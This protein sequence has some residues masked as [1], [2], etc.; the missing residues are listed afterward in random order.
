MYK[1][2]PAFKAPDDRNAKIWHYMDI[3]KFLSLIM[4]RKLFFGRLDRTSDPLDGSVAKLNVRQ[5]DQVY[6][7]ASKG[8]IESMARFREQ[9]RKHMVIHCWHLNQVES[10]AMWKLYLKSDEGVAI[11]STFARLCDSFNGLE[12]YDVHVGMIEYIDFDSELVPEDD[13]FR[14]A[15]YKRKSFAYEHEVRAVI[16]KFPEGDA[17]GRQ[18]SPFKAGLAV[19]VDMNRLIEKVYVSP[20]SELWIADL[21]RTLVDKFETNLPVVHSTLDDDPVF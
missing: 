1:P 6:R 17:D 16:A 12:E 21:I 11:Q 20:S 3:T 10:A 9:M 7:N 19:P 2:H 18:P 4:T 15:V 13:A 8:E 5:R 14:P